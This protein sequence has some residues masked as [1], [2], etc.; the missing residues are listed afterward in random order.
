M[1]TLHQV[2]SAKD[3]ETFISIGP[4]TIHKQFNP[5]TAK[6]NKI[7]SS[8]VLKSGSDEMFMTMWETAAEWKL[9]LGETLTL[10]GRFTKNTFNGSASLNCDEL[11]KPEGAVAVKPE[12]IQKPVEKPTIKECLET[13]IRAADYMIRKERPELAEVAFTF[14]ANAMLQGAKA[15]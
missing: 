15:E 12:D 9:P 4:V 8:V 3:G 13:G 2:A 1:S 5:K 7:F 6:N 11:S 14:A 10:R